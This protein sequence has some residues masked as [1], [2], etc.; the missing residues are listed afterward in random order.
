MTRERRAAN[1]QPTA[2]PAAGSGKTS[3]ASNG[4]AVTIVSPNTWPLIKPAGTIIPLTL[5]VQQMSGAQNVNIDNVHCTTTVK[6]K[7]SAPPISSP[8]RDSTIDIIDGTT[9]EYTLRNWIQIVPDPGF[10][11]FAADVSI[12][13]RAQDSSAGATVGPLSFFADTS[14][15]MRFE[16]E[17]TDEEVTVVPAKSKAKGK[18]APARGK[19]KQ[20]G[21]RRKR[22]GSGRTKRHRATGKNGRPCTIVLGGGGEVAPTSGPVSGGKSNS[23]VP[24]KKPVMG[25]NKMKGGRRV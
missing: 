25:K 4:I 7:G 11:S 14:I 17:T 12:N 16:E 10:S 5:R 15:G 1:Q 6:P 3:A 21:R 24:T 18:S 9:K 20:K 19:A 13:C 8:L 22:N 2:A 23:K